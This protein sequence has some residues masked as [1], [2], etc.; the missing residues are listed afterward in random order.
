[1]L[2]PLFDLPELKHDWSDDKKLK[3]IEKIYKELSNPSH[4]ASL[5]M[6]R[7]WT[8]EDVRIIEGL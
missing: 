7:Q 3:T 1:M 2:K 5:A 6:Q 4:P 8:V